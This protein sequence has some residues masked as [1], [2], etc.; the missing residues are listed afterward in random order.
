MTEAIEY[1]TINALGARVLNRDMASILKGDFLC[2]S[3]GLDTISTGGVIAFAIEC[4]ENGII[5][6][7]D[8]GGL[9]LKWGD[10]EVVLQLNS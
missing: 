5:T 6:R 9:E 8:T 10:P 3:Y 2:D 4:F 1:E 7:E